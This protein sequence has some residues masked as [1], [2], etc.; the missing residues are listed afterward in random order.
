MMTDEERRSNP[1]VHA[2]VDLEWSDAR[3]THTGRIS[4]LGMGGC[5]IDTPERVNVQDKVAL[6]V[7]VSE[8][9]LLLLQGE[10]LYHDENAGFGVRFMALGPEQASALADLINRSKG[11][12]Q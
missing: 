9:K 5:Y 8:G 2:S 3:G 10:V 4:T 1:R 11:G 6:Q 7:P 12:K